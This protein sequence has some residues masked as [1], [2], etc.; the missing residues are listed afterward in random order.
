MK[1]VHST[2]TATE[3]FGRLALCGLVGTVAIITV[4]SLAPFRFDLPLAGADAFFGLSQFRWII[5]PASDF[6][7]NIT[8]YIPLGVFA[9]L[10]GVRL[11]V[12]RWSAVMIAMAIAT[13]MSVTLE[14]VQTTS[15]ARVASWLDVTMNTAG[16]AFGSAIVGFG[17]IGWTC[18]ATT[19]AIR[20]SP[21]TA[22]NAMTTLAVCFLALAPFD[23]VTSTA[24]LQ[25]SM[26]QSRLAFDF[27]LESRPEIIRECLM[28]LGYAAQFALIAFAKSRSCLRRGDTPAEIARSVMGHVALVAAAIELSQLFTASHAL[29]VFDLTAAIAGGCLG[30][31]FGRIREVNAKSIERA[32]C[33]LVVVQAAYFIC[34]SAWP[35]DFAMSTESLVNRLAQARPNLI[36]FAGLFHRPFTAA[37]ADLA[38]TIAAY[39][40]FAAL[41]WLAAHG[42]TRRLRMTIVI[43]AGAGVAFACEAIQLASPTRFADTAGPAIAFLVAVAICLLEP[44]IAGL[45]WIT[46]PALGIER[47]T[48]NRD[49]S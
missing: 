34:L 4:G 27:G 24:A 29:D 49:K 25:N 36:P 19:N 17:L 42:W 13:L 9:C 10:L 28:L 33:G 38:T 15:S 12:A 41:A 7:A 30:L 14:T 39:A 40:T 46:A 20:K 11:G 3:G 16:A 32:V 48:K 43:L 18:S 35:F 45:V 31:A 26:R 47:R 23:L 2:S 5:G 21:W 22:I 1:S 8:A 37:A 44:H 6:A